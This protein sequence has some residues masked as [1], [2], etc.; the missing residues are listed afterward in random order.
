M[1]TDDEQYSLRATGSSMPDPHSVNN[2]SQLPGVIF[3]E[4]ELE[5]VTEDG[6]AETE[7]LT[8]SPPDFNKAQTPAVRCRGILRT[9]KKNI[10][11]L[12]LLHTQVWVAAAYS[13]L[14]PLFPALAV[15]RGLGAWQYGFVFSVGKI[16]TIIG[17]VW[18]KRLIQQT[19]PKTM[20]IT[21]QVGYFLANAVYGALYWIPGDYL[22]L[23][24][25]LFGG[26]LGG[27]TEA[28]YCVSCY[29]TIM[30]IF[31]DNPGT[32]I[33]GLQ[34][35]W[36]CGGAAGAVT[37]GALV[38]LWGYP[39]G[40]LII[41]SCF[42]LSLPL[43]ATSTAFRR[44]QKPADQNSLENHNHNVGKTSLKHHRLF[45]DFCFVALL[46]NLFLFGLIYGFL[47]PTLE[48]YLDHFYQSSSG[49]G[50]VFSVYALSFCIASALCAAACHYKAELHLLPVALLLCIVGF[51]IMGPAPFLPFEPSIGLIYAS[52]VLIGSGGASL[53][54]LSYTCVL[55][56]AI[57]KGYPEDM[58]TNSFVSG[59]VFATYVSGATLSPPIS[60]YIVEALGFRKGSMVLLAVLVAWMPPSLILQKKLRV[61]PS[62]A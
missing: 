25:A 18:S 50:S 35:L 37:G 57:A 12:P 3:T 55:R 45:W 11:I 28:V 7:T 54:S 41:S 5:V 30:L 13:L 8:S 52:Q 31:A 38:D 34:F 36:G 61:K 16:A 1:T 48:P 4:N 21:G 24:V 43:I 32:A 62:R 49:I 2:V 27:F 59:A 40:F 9:C 51:I 53:H 56:H 20:F 26:A 42:M 60:G 6:I 22:M 29:S 15:S 46:F 17:S 14:A 10:Y 44:N 19:S 58:D 33:A 47:E 23:G 39:A